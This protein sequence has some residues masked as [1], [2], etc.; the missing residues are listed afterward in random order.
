VG[1]SRLTVQFRNELKLVGLEL[2]SIFF[3]EKLFHTS[4][5][6]MP[7]FLST[8]SSNSLDDLQVISACPCG[9]TLHSIGATSQYFLRCE[10][11]QTQEGFD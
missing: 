8:S 4:Q 9:F 7:K 11:T 2:Y 3:V 10:L 6:P 5:R 1:L